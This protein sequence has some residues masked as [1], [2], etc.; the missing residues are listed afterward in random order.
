MPFVARL[1]CVTAQSNACAL[2]G[3]AAASTNLT[4]LCLER[5]R[6][7]FERTSLSRARWSA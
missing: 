6:C 2:R 5:S 3:I 4:V 7:C 1:L